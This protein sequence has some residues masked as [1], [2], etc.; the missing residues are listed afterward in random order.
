ML[1]GDGSTWGHSLHPSFRQ[2]VYSRLWLHE[3]KAVRFACNLKCSNKNAKTTWLTVT[4]VWL[5][6]LLK[7]LKV[8]ASSGNPDHNP[9]RQALFRSWVPGKPSDSPTLFLYHRKII[10]IPF[11]FPNGL[12]CGISIFYFIFWAVW[13][14]NKIEKRVQRFP[15]Y[16]LLPHI[17]SL[18]YQHHSPEWCVCYQGWTYISTL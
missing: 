15:L 8:I 6:V 11:H 7:P 16:P 5:C 9:V 4:E 1:Q 18:H 10:H 13:V 14:Y 3:W 2:W 17:H 12:W